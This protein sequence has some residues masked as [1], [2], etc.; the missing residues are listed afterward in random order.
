MDEHEATLELDQQS[1]ADGRSIERALESGSLAAEAALLPL[2]R[3]ASEAKTL[4]LRVAACRVIGAISGRAYDATWEL[5][6][7]A[8]FALL[9]VARE[10]DAPAERVLLLQAMGRGFRNA[11][12]M[13]YVHSRLSADEGSV[14]VAAISAAGGLAFPA[15]E[16]TIAS[17][18][19]NVTSGEDD[20][21]PELRA[22]AIAALGRMG[23]HTAAVRLAAIVAKGGE[24][25]SAA[26]SALTEIRTRVGADAALSLLQGDP[27]R[28]VLLAAVRYLSEIGDARVQ[29]ILR[30]L[31]REEDA[32]LRLAASLA[33]RALEAETKT[34]PDER[35]LAA[36]TERDRAVRAMLARR[37][38]TLPVA[39]V[40]AQAKVLLADDPLG[41]I[42]IVAEV[43]APEV[44]RMLL[45]IA[46][47]ETLPIDVRARAAGSIEA[48][49]EWE[50]DALLAL[51]GS[52]RD[53]AVRVAAAQTLGA[54]AETDLVLDRLS[55]LAEDP[56]P[57]VRAALLWT[58]QLCARP[59]GRQRDRAKSKAEEIVKRALKDPDVAVRRRAAYVAANLDAAA[60]VPDLVTLARENTGS[61]GRADLRIAAF[62]ALGDIASPARFNDLVHL[63]N[64]EE[65]AQALTAASRAIERSSEADMPPLSQRGVSLP[66]RS[67]PASLA[68]VHD[69]LPKLLSSPDARVRAAAVRVAGLTLGSGE[70]IRPLVNDP[71]PRVR[72]KAVVAL[73]RIVGK[74]A[75]EELTAALD[76]ADAAVQER[77]AEAL[78]R[79]DATGRVIDFV[80]RVP[81]RSLA[82][83]IATKLLRKTQSLDEAELGVVGTALARVDHDDPVYELLLMLKLSALEALRPTPS[84]ALDGGGSVDDAIAKA[85]PTWTH[86]RGVRGFAPL[87][88]S[89]R[90]AE[91]LFASSE[92]GGGGGEADL[93]AAIVL[94]M[95]CLEG[96]MHAWLAPRLRSLHERSTTL[97]ELSDRLL[98]SSW[99]SY[100]KWLS[101]RWMD[102]VKIGALE[103]EVPLRSVVNALR[104]L[105]ENKGSSR[106]LDSPMSVTEWS[107]ILLFLGVD[108]PT[109]AKN[110]LS[111]GGSRAKPEGTVR[112]LHR[113]QVLAQV[114]NA[115]THRLTT[116]AVTLKEFRRSYYAAFEEL[117]AM[118]K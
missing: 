113:L 77:A 44:T 49:E 65:D 83:R 71:S 23:A 102:P 79:V 114:R 99:P 97:W 112:L 100:Q 76:D 53:A 54:F 69:R 27:S 51:V 39:D 106:S 87:A 33:A 50:R 74:E 67:A 75:E 48:D 84:G 29:P 42:Q 35:I 115:A 46:E 21:E 1:A 118:A 96:Y 30:S 59:T 32:E 68:R 25:T 95:K 31:A 73:G 6:E 98:S 3:A 104:D 14:V 36:L 12:L 117:T 8:A 111:I 7:R 41:V 88:R 91:M 94:W 80:S 86:L 78:L 40:L 103:V 22:A 37:L 63:W 9:E 58:L 85:F 93:S 110:V 16:E 55:S 101:E 15:L 72:E 43:R 108:H 38:R 20:V 11:W 24:H 105:Q 4:G 13:P 61:D 60:L 26:L 34:D 62:V 45:E 18:F 107:R 28:D 2:V 116:D 17:A 89:L 92:T 109:G 64:R 52:S 70:M 82:L 47:D 19:L 90:T 10:A 66:P 56:E 57:A 81:D 5:A